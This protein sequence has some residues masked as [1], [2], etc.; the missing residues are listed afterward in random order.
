MFK[1]SVKRICVGVAIAIIHFGI[2]Y[3]IANYA[4]VNKTDNMPVKSSYM[5]L[6]EEDRTW[7]NKAMVSQTVKD[8]YADDTTIVL[9]AL[10]G[11][12]NIVDYNKESK[13]YINWVRDEYGERDYVVYY[14]SE[15]TADWD[16]LK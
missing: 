10:T 15:I 13:M 3:G 11:P 6:N 4:S 5:Y 2:G 9:N 12:D 1:I 8:E 16:H 7:L 14:G